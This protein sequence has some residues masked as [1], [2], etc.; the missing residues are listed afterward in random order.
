V[1]P[2]LSRQQIEKA[3]NKKRKVIYGATLFVFGYLMLL[4]LFGEVSLPH[5]L[6]MRSA[7]QQINSEIIRLKS[8]NGS[9]KNE[10]EALRSNPNQ[11]E[12]LARKELGLTKKGEIIY[13]FQTND[14]A[15]SNLPK[16]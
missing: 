12:N 6:S 8:E 1:T 16:Q 13:E 2:N 4:F 11:I 7:Y 14:P 15:P 3:R 5:Y 9:L 10:T